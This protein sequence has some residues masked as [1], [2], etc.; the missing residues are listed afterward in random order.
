MTT[1]THTPGPW[2]L[3]EELDPTAADG[4]TICVMLGGAE[5][6]PAKANARLIVGAPDMLAALQDAVNTCLRC[7]GKGNAYTMPDETEIG[8]PPGSSRIDCPNC[9]SWRAAIAKATTP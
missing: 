9:A 3:D 5:I 8:Q 6:E 2:H 1:A 7:D 4:T